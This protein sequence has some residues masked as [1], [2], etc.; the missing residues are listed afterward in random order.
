MWNMRKH[1]YDLKEVKDHKKG[2]PAP[3]CERLCKIS[4]VV[5]SERIS[6]DSLINF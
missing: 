1:G 4:A 5:H 3:F 6:P 2:L